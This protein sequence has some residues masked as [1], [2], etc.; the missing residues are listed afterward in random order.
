MIKTAYFASGCFWGTE[1][2]LGQVDGV[3]STTAG[4]IGG[5]LPNPTYEQVSTGNT[6]HVEA[7]KVDYDS[8]KVSYEDLAKVFFESH[9][10]TQVG[11]QGPD[12]GPQYLSK[13]FY[14]T[15]E[16]QETAQKLIGILESKGMKIATKVEKATTFYPAEAYHQDYFA[17]NNQSQVCHV[18]QKLF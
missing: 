13:I 2:Y 15:N 14:T 9:D 1:Y 7:A 10:P 6:G 16:E 18:Y 8:E 17:K 5:E 12:F 11:G 3:V 4:Y